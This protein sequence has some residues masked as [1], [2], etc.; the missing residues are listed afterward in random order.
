M[1]VPGQLIFVF[2][3]NALNPGNCKIHAYFVFFYVTV[4]FIQVSH[5]IL[6]FYFNF[7]NCGNEVIT[8]IFSGNAS[9]V[10]RTHNHSRDVEVQNRS[11]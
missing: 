1:A 7:A 3:A 2:V 9:V 8:E 4:S 5:A 11:R 6:L 10:H